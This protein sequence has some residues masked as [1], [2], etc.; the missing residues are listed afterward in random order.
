MDKMTLNDKLSQ[1]AKTIYSY[2]LVRTSTREEAQDLSQDI[3][4]E[5]IK[6]ACNLRDDNA[7]YGF[8]WGVAGNVYKNWCKKRRRPVYAELDENLPD[9]GQPVEEQLMENDD[10][11]LLRRELSLLSEK[12]R[13]CAVLYYVE[14]YP[15]SKIARTL[16]ITESMVKYLL[17][18]ARKKLKEGMNMVRS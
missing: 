4:L 13:R 2:C 12:Y 10:I 5:I 16:N 18:K 7:F 17:F 3:L 6:S 8:M 14:E 15:V 1:A 11:A 9:Q